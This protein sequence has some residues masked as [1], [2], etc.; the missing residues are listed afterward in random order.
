[1]VLPLIPILGKVALIIKG[2]AAKAAAGGAVV[3]S[4]KAASTKA[5]SS[6]I[7]AAKKLLSG[8]HLL[9][10]ENKSKRR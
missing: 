5:G 2:G 4:A 3:G 9:K 1:M 7:A 10:D 8:R 6:K